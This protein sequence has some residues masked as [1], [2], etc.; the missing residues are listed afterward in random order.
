VAYVLLTTREC[1]GKQT[2]G[3]RAVHN[4]EVELSEYFSLPSLPLVK[5][6]GRHEVL[7]RL[8]V[9]PDAHEGF[10]TLPGCSWVS[11]PAITPSEESV[12]TW[13]GGA[14]L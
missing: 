2:L 12:P 9:S 14:G 6:L 7:K 4:R 10:H 13:V 8:V 1:V 5:L 3:T 11:T